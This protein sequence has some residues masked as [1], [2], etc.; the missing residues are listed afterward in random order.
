MIFVVLIR[1]DE[2][3]VVLSASRNFYGTLKVIDYNADDPE[4]HYYLLKH[5]ATTHGLQYAKPP[6]STWP[7]TYY[8]ESSGVGLAIR[9]LPR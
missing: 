4:S 3:R 7:T 1:N 5:G 8:A 2:D 9:H 6:Q